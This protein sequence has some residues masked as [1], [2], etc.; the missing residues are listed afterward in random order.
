MS[1]AQELEI[2]AGLILEGVRVEDPA[3]FEGVGSRYLENINYAFDFTRD[4]LAPGTLQPSELIFPEGTACKFIFNQRSPYRVKREDGT[5][6]LE[7]GDRVLTTFR[8]NERPAF[9][10]RKTSYGVEMRRILQFRG[11]DGLVCCVSNTCSY[12]AEGKECR[13]CN[14]NFAQKNTVTGAT[15]KE[16]LYTEQQADQV[17]EVYRAALEEGYNPCFVISSG[18]LPGGRESEAAVRIVEAIQRHTGLERVRGCVNISAPAD[19]SDVDR[20]HEAGIENLA[21][22]LEVWNPHLF[23]AICPGKAQGGG[24]EHWKRALEYAVSV[25]GR[26]N[27]FSAFV[28]GLEERE[29]YYEAA[30]WLGERG[31]CAVMVPWMP[32]RGS[33]LEGHRPPQLEWV[34]ETHEKV[35]DLTARRLPEILTREFSNR[36]K[37]NC[38]RCNCV[39][40]LWDE[41]RKRLGEFYKVQPK[42]REKQEAK[43]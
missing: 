6:C 32:Q 24:Q 1:I 23:Q 37:I 29:N 36:S 19:L 21:I 25:F 30:D 2:K 5:L 27:V 8:W 34:L 9:Y 15:L 22:N 40:I 12:W 14:Y 11:E 28:M 16:T 39:G 35:I 4:T 13:Y 18:T 41:L 7:K 26:G 3:A 31:V 33:R 42:D 17:G 10:D 20:I 38:Y 43:V